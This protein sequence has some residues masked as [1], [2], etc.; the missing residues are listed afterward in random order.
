MSDFEF[1]EENT[2]EAVFSMEVGREM[3]DHNKLYNRYADDQHP[4]SAITGLTEALAEGSSNLQEEI[5]RAEAAE[6]ALDDKIDAETTRAEGVESGLNTAISNETSARIQA[7]TTLQNNIT[8]EENRAKGIENG[9]RS[10]LTAETTRAEGVE[11][12]LNTAISNETSARIQADTTLQNNITAEENRA[13]GIE[14]GLR[15]DLTAETT[16]RQDADTGLQNQISTNASNI[17]TLQSGKADKSTTYTKTE[18]NTIAT[19]KANVG[20]DNLNADGQMIID[21]QNGTISNCILEIPQN[22]KVEINGSTL[23]HKSGSIFVLGGSTYTTYTLTQDRSIDLS[24]TADGRYVVQPGGN[25]APV[26]TLLSKSFSGSE[27]PASASSGDRF[28]NV[29][30]K[31]FWLYGTSWF[32]SGVMYPSCIVDVANGVASFAKDSHGN[33]M[34]FNGLGFI[35][36][37]KFLLPGVKVLEPIGKNPDGSLKSTEITNNTLQLVT[38]GG[39]YNR[40]M[41]LRDSVFQITNNAWYYDEDKNLW[42]DQNNI[43]FN[44]GCVLLGNSFTVNDLVTYFTISQPYEGARNLLTDDL[45]EEVATKQVDVT[46]LTGYDSTQTQTLKNI[47]G[48]LTWVTD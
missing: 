38:Q 3:N 46:T 12:G 27:L 2:I 40:K 43:P 9:L 39:T 33:D 6:Q 11:S 28:F 10:D 44:S 14:N 18:V 24:T 37:T 32:S 31:T 8:A 16:A 30:D 20:L 23:T 29:I 48:V 13:K 34:I 26:I 17:T 35:G 25:G 45:E 22:I 4:I 19:G 15:S 36:Q 1:R 42:Y 5:S 21:S 7:D 41:Y 47:N